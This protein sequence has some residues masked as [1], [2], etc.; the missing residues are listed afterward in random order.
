MTGQEAT[1]SELPLHGAGDELRLAREK[2]GL[3]LEQVAAETRIPQR[4]LQLIEKGDFSGLPARTYAIGFARSYARFVGLDEKVIAAKV[5]EELGDALQPGANRAQNFEPHDPA[6]VPTRGLA[7]AMLAAA[8]LLAA[9]VFAFYRSA[10]APGS[11]PPALSEPQVQP[12]TPAASGAPAATA[13]DAGGEVV[14]TALDD[15]VWIK[16]YD[17]D[18]VQLMQRQMAKGETYAV[19]ADAKG[20]MVWTGRPDA[21]SITVGGMPVPKLADAERI[22]R[23]VP[24]SAAALLARPTP[25][26]SASGAA[27]TTPAASPTPTP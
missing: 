23:D 3:S 2:Q 18:G 17:A 8:L 26:P 20:P 9:G 25:A 19:P 22:L 7:W 14:F 12:T 5:R 16:F 6:R 10:I 27:A 13:P 11:G 24:V 1:N 15:N 4:H 21:F